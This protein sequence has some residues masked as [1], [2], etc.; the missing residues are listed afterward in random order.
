MATRGKRNPRRSGVAILVILGA[1]LVG[2][3][4]RYLVAVTGNY[5]PA[6]LQRF[7]AVAGIDLPDWYGQEPFLLTWT[8]GDGQVFLALAAD[9]L[10]RGEGR[11][12]LSVDYRLQRIGYSLAGAAL[13]LWREDLLSIGLLA[14]NALAVALLAWTTSSLT[15]RDRR[16]W[17]LLANPAVLIGFAGDSAEPLGVCVLVGAIAATRL[18]TAGGFGAAVGLIR[19]DYGLALGAAHKPLAAIAGWLASATSAFLIIASAGLGST[20]GTG[21]LT[22]PFVG[23]VE[24]WHTH[25]VADRLLLAVVVLAGVL[26]I[27]YSVLVRGLA[28]ISFLLV[29]LITIC[30]S[31][32]VLDLTINLVRLTAPMPVLW[33]FGS[34]EKKAQLTSL[35]DGGVS[36]P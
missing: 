4:F 27:G 31:I 16:Y 2:V 36:N 7:E 6:D 25:E 32:S 21:N 11:R 33:V 20:W 18:G 29:G 26:T 30:Y 15:L 34:I 14:A 22:W 3:G 24:A 28:R 9:P 12:V 1:L 17:W 23:Y 8:R 19:P 35:P 13:V 5:G 10:L